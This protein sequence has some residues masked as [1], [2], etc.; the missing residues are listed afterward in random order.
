MFVDEPLAALRNRVEA[1]AD[2]PLKQ[3]NHAGSQADRSERINIAGWLPSFEDRD[4]EM[5]ASRIV[6]CLR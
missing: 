6:G 4:N 1:V 2:H 3:L 5:R